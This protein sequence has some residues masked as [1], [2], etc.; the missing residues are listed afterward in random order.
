MAAKKAKQPKPPAP[1]AMGKAA[2]AMGSKE[3]S[4]K[5]RGTVQA[6]KKASTTTSRRQNSSAGDLS[7]YG[8][9]KFSEIGTVS[10]PGGRVSQRAK[11]QEKR[12]AD[13]PAS[14]QAAKYNIQKISTEKY[15]QKGFYNTSNTQEALY[16][17]KKYSGFKITPMRSADVKPSPKKTKTVK[18][19]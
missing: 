1:A 4:A 7:G 13:K 9:P 15:V 16:P 5:T 2:A 19:K 11:D 6:N 18:K 10:F 17:G 12:K 8:R 14:K 3:T